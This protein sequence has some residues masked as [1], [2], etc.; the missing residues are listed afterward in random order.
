MR[1]IARFWIAEQTF[2]HILHRR[3]CGGPSTISGAPDSPLKMVLDR[4]RN[5]ISICATECDLAIRTPLSYS[6]GSS[7]CKGDAQE[8]GTSTASVPAAADGNVESVHRVCVAYGAALS[9]DLSSPAHK[10]LSYLTNSQYQ[11]EHLNDQID[12]INST[13]KDITLGNML[14]L[15]MKMGI[16]TNQVEF[17]TGL[18]SKALESTKTIMNIQV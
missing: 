10:F 9:T 14:A 7:Q 13:G 12:Y 2:H 18:L 4:D 3:A 15:Q 8:R 6:R 1:C 17:F 11:L 5:H 16:V